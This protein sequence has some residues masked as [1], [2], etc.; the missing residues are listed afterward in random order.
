MLWKLLKVDPVV[1]L[2][3]GCLSPPHS[4]LQELLE[5]EAANAKP[6]EDLIEEERRKVDARTPITGE[7]GCGVS[8]ISAPAACVQHIQGACCH[9]TTTL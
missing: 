8:R 3:M 6:I 2:F 4:M 9:S 1:V 7:V 5:E